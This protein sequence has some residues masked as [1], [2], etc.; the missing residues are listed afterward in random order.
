MARPCIV[1]QFPD[2]V[3]YPTAW[4][5]QTELVQARKLDPHLPDALMVLE[6]PPV[7][8]LGQGSTRQFLKFDLDN[9]PAPVYFT[10]R[11]GEVTYHSIGQLVIYPI[12]HLQFHQKDL[13]WYLRQLE[14]VIIHTLADYGLTAHRKQGLT[15]VWIVDRKIA[16]IGIKVSRWITMH[17]VSLNV[18]MDMA[19]FTKI[20]PCGIKDYGCTQLADFISPIG[21]YQVIPTALYYFQQVFNLELSKNY[22]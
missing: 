16:Q 18:N 14:T 12:F 1:Y 10:E 20:V 5:M 7:Y 8:T 19:G 21:L 6:H 22:L 3:P 4:Q 13:H 11:G 17:G 9:P 2:P 15:G